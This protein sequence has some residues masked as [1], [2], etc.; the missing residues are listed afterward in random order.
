M[1]KP[2]SI[3]HIDCYCNLCVSEDYHSKQIAANKTTFQCVVAKTIILVFLPAKIITPD[4]FVAKKITFKCLW[5]KIIV[6]VFGP[7]KNITSNKAR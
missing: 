1:P 6:P 5:E 7:V 3:A 4:L 2:L